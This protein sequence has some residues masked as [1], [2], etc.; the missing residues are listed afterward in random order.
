MT[1]RS[2]GV[3]TGSGRV[4]GYVVEQGEPGNVVG[5][6]DYLPGQGIVQVG[7]VR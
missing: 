5:A 4:G 6:F 1:A 2:A 7:H 3:A